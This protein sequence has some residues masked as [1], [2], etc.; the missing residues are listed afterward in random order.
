MF[1]RAL[2]AGAMLLDHLLRGVILPVPDL[3]WVTD[4][5]NCSLSELR[6]SS[7][8]LHGLGV[9]DLA[10]GTLLMAHGLSATCDGRWSYNL[11]AW[12]HDVINVPAGSGGVT[13]IG[14]AARLELALTPT[15]AVSMPLLCSNC[16]CDATVESVQ[17]TGGLSA[18]LVN[19][20]EDTLR[21]H[22]QRLLDERACAE[23]SKRFSTSE[24]AAFASP[25]KL[26]GT[27][28][29]S[30]R[31][32]ARSRLL[33]G[34]L[35]LALVLSAAA[36]AAACTQAGLDSLRLWRRQHAARTL[37]ATASEPLLPRRG[38]GGGGV[39]GGGSGSAAELRQACPDSSDSEGFVR[40]NDGSAAGG[41]AGDGGTAA[42]AEVARRGAAPNPEWGELGAV[43]ACVCG[44][45][46]MQLLL[47][48]Q[49]LPAASPPWLP[50]AMRGA[51]D[52]PHLLLLLLWA[53]AREA[54]QPGLPSPLPGAQPSEP[55]ATA[56]PPVAA[57][58]PP[59]PPWDAIPAPLLA[60]LALLGLAAL[61]PAFAA[62]AL[63]AATPLR[64]S[65]PAAPHRP[66]SGPRAVTAAARLGGCGRA[67]QAAHRA[68]AAA[69]LWLAE[70]SGRWSL[71]P[72]VLG[73]LV[74]AAAQTAVPLP[75]NNTNDAAN[76]V[77]AAAAVAA[78]AAWVDGTALA[79]R[80]AASPGHTAAVA[81]S[82]RARA[83]ARIELRLGCG[84]LLHALAAAA[85]L[86][87]VQ[88][89]RAA[90]RARRPPPLAVTAPSATSPSAAAAA[91][92]A[93][94]GARARARWYAR[95]R[96]ALHAA[97]VL[98]ACVALPQPLVELQTRV[99]A[100]GRLIALTPPRRL[101]ILGLLLSAAGAR[102]HA[103]VH[104]CMCMHFSCTAACARARA[105]L[106]HCSRPQA[107]CAPPVP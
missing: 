59:P 106:M 11:A 25:H 23:L 83:T 70:A 35:A 75:D 7:V 79:H 50:A 99:G 56:G 82:S 48:V 81:A 89:A 13:A 2:V 42:G 105:L 51:P 76:D 5:I 97:S 69:A 8:R 49:L 64:A 91:A 84:V 87:A 94:G 26:L 67:L 101:S 95:L 78:A 85:A 17:F 61:W 9:T 15:A 93:R 46:G 92:T 86:L 40:R 41:A 43:W 65:R 54:V 80:G 31:G 44:A 12:P 53:E 96:A 55:V 27:S 107:R 60:L 16:T 45:L 21:T 10:P 58:V 100:A 77:L 66:H 90:A 72:A 6:C 30:T 38:G 22:M 63:C 71:T 28:R 88:H 57:L 3:S 68:A 36:A 73:L 20:F 39:G 24:T 4:G 29:M 52:A 33:L 37:P 1:E 19:H 98:V 62:A 74:C 18:A 47:A 32:V 14:G 104:V 102:T 103:R 34:V